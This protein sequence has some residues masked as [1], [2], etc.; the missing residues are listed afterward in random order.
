MVSA[1]QGNWATGCAPGWACFSSPGGAATNAA[2]QKDS[3]MVTDRY[4]ADNTI[5]G[6][7]VS[8]ITNY[9]TTI[10]ARPYKDPGYFG[11]FACI[12]KK[13]GGSASGGGGYPIGS[14]GGVSAW[15]GC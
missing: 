12:P 4:F 3:S 6:D 10:G 11:P 2:Y 15:K 8:Y 13:V 9:M 1:D 7:R 5:M 14:A